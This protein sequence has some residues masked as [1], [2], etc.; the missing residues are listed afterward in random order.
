MGKLA[1]MAKQTTSSNTETGFVRKIGAPFFPVERSSQTPAQ[2]HSLNN[3]PIKKER[4]TRQQRLQG[5]GLPAKK[6]ATALQSILNEPAPDNR[7]SL[8]TFR[9]SVMLDCDLLNEIEE[10]TT[11]RGL[12]EWGRK[13]IFFVAENSVPTERLISEARNIASRRKDAATK[14]LF[15]S[16]DLTLMN[17]IEILGNRSRLTD[18]EVI[19]ACLSIYHMVHIRA[20]EGN[21]L[22]SKLNN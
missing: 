11:K 22:E 15:I 21:T 10:F 2:E 6:L 5:G 19:E 17:T 7:E 16:L 14:S 12:P 4:V 20:T 8:K 9:R 1:D 18:K 3:S 13:A